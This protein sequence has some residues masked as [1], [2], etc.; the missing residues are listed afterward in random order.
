MDRRIVEMTA[1]SDVMVSR[2]GLTGLLQT[3]AARAQE[4]TKADYAA[5]STFDE[6]GMLERFIYSGISEEQARR[7]GAP[8]L[9]RG[10]LGS[11]LLGGDQSIRCVDVTLHEA[12]TGWPADHPSMGPFLGVPVRVGGRTIGSLYMTRRAGEPGFSDEE[13]LSAKFLALQAAT[14]MWS[15]LGRAREGRM[16][17]LEERATIAR[18]LHDGTIQSLYALGLE[19]DTHSRRPRLNR[20]TRKMLAASVDRLNQLIADI[21]QYITML[22]A[23]APPNVP[24]LA[25]DLPFAL[26]QIVPPGIDTVLNIAAAALQ[27]LP[28]RAEEDLLYIAREALSNAVRHGQPTRLAV[29]LRQTPA[30]TTLVV[31]DNGIG[32]DP[33]NARVGLGSVS[34]RTRAERLG[35]ALTIVTIPGMGTTVR[36]AVPRD[37]DGE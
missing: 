20:D 3:V 33:A 8:P 31:Q 37:L 27:E 21:R 13:E 34:M 19:L 23:S 11:P 30:E 35:A 4:V 10:L 9:G 16:A 14:C 25:Q 26:R 1:T 6:G 17:V 18:D 5:I 28:P 15:E 12:F 24:D 7:L 36:V 22:E 29:D 2:E 32:F